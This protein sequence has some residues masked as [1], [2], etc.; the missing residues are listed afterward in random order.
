[1]IDQAKAVR[2]G[3]ELPLERL[4][5]YL[6]EQLGTDAPVTVAQFP[7]GHS[8][9]TYLVT[10]GD[11]E[12]VLRRPPFG[13]KVKS[14]H[15][16]GREVR[17][18]SHLAPVYPRAPRPVLFCEDEEVMGARFYLMERIAGVILRKPPLPIALDAATARR[19]CE[20]LVDALAELHALDPAAIGLGDFG[21][22]EGYVERQVS[23]WAR[24][25][26]DSKTDDV[27]DIERAAAWLA[28]HI[29]RSPAPALIHNDY[30]FDNLVLD[31]SDVTR[32]RGIL[33][34]EMATI[35]DPLMD[36][37]TTLCYW[38]EASDPDDMKMLSFGPTALP[39]MM[40]RAEVA[41]RY[42]EKTG[43]SVENIDFYLCFGF[44]KT[45][46]VVQQIYYRWKKGLTADPRFGALIAGVRV[47]GREAARIVS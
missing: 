28:A 8:N 46:V 41:T 29:P 31:P 11:K 4:T 43:R 23:G 6:Q 13:S 3:E 37:G 24:R 35:G 32:I 33:D 16:M 22:P 27:P 7:G 26:A 39:G 18:L 5:P 36:L 30:K 15:D 10:V 14:A 38:V 47:L 34:W 42:A 12:Y 17:V 25:Y 21:N 19:V 44:F 1:M 9:L 20:G 45:A 40:T 2:K